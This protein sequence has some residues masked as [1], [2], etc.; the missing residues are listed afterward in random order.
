MTPSFYAV[1]LRRQITRLSLELLLP[2]EKV[3][4]EVY[5][6]GDY[7]GKN[8]RK[9]R[10]LSD[11]S[12]NPDGGIPTNPMLINHRSDDDIKKSV[13]SMNGMVVDTGLMIACENRRDEIQDALNTLHLESR[14][15]FIPK[16]ETVDGETLDGED[17]KDLS[18]GEDDVDIIHPPAKLVPAAADLPDQFLQRIRGGVQLQYVN[19][20][21]REDH[22][23]TTADACFVL[24][25]MYHILLREGG[26]ERQ[27]IINKA[28]E[29]A[30]HRYRRIK[31]ANQ[32][33]PSIL[34]KTNSLVNRLR[35]EHI[36]TERHGE[37]HARM[38]EHPQ[39]NLT[40]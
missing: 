3:P 20:I 17:Y 37:L 27:E 6:G 2:D 30:T 16:I 32:R 35:D 4:V 9:Y 23:P 25:E 5:N 24:Q 39:Q 26:H 14:I 36:I 40:F 34:D 28:W 15:D 19:S 11:L 10:Q 21:Y 13:R 38:A 33:K 29:S 8:T 7:L 31:S 12:T 22:E 1:N 18:R